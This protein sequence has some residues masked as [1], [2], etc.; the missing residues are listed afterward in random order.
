[1]VKV[2]YGIRF[3]KTSPLAQEIKLQK[4]KLKKYVVQNNT[5]QACKIALVIADLLLSQADYI[6]TD[7]PMADQER[8]MIDHA[9]EALKYCQKSNPVFISNED[10]KHLARYILVIVDIDVY[11]SHSRLDNYNDAITIGNDLVGLFKQ[12]QPKVKDITLLQESY[13]LLADLY[14]THGLLGNHISKQTDLPLALKYYEKERKVLNTIKTDTL[15]G[16]DLINYTDNIRCSDFNLGVIKAK[17]MH[18][19]RSSSWPDG[20]TAE[21]H[22]KMAIKGSIDLDNVDQERKTWWELGNLY[23]KRGQ[24]DEALDCQMKELNLVRKH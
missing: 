18:S 6:D 13:K 23:N 11:A 16:D 3:S 21:D 2:T 1:M 10:Y 14:F 4:T 19:S 15:K 22:L 5:R 20:E 12:P 24:L 7:L 17:L 8:D 9:N